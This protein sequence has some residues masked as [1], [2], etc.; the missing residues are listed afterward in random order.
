MVW[1]VVP[2]EQ[3]LSTP[4]TGVGCLGENEVVVIADT[5]QVEVVSKR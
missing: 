2:R 3:V 1:T 4:A 5:L